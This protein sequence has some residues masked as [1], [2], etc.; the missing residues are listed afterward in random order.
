MMYKYVDTGA[1]SIC[2]LKVC[3]K[4]KVHF[5]SITQLQEVDNCK[6]SKHNA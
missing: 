3:V 1:Y 2:P 4:V 6:K 5:Q